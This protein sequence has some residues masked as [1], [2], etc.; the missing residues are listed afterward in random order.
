LVDKI[1]DSIPDVAI[2]T[3]II[4]GFPGETEE[5]F[6]ETLDIVSKVEFDSAFTFIYSVREGTPAAKYTDQVPEEVKH[7]RFN[8]L[9]D[10]VNKMGEKKSLSYN[11]KIVEVLVEGYSK[12]DESKLT[13]R[14]SGGKLVNFDG[15]DLSLKGKLVNVKVTDSQMYLLSGYYLETVR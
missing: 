9:L 8:R 11:N 13:G 14:T 10:L 7:E 15:G 2:T 4:V 1:K 12:T 6:N 5:D 3:D